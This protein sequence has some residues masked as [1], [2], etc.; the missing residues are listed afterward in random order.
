MYRLF[1]V[2]PAYE[3]FHSLSATQSNETLNFLATEET[4]NMGITLIVTIRLKEKTPY[5]YCIDGY[6]FSTLKLTN[7]RD[8]RA[9]GVGESGHATGGQGSVGGRS[10]W[11]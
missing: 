10:M 8:S 5:H 7:S 11:L 9:D 6:T 1:G 3:G 4:I 2:C